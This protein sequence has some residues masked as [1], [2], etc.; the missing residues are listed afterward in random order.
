MCAQTAQLSPVDAAWLHMEDPTNLMMVTG[1]MLLKEPVDFARVRAIYRARLLQ[2]P[3]FSQRVVE[4]SVPLGIPHWEPDPHFVF[5]AHVHHVALP[6]PGTR[7][8]L[9][10]FL[11]DIASTPLDFSKPLWHLHVID[12]VEGRSAIAMR[13]HHCIGDG[14]ALVSVI[15]RLVDDRP[16]APV[17]L[18]P[19][20]R[21]SRA[22]SKPRGWLAGLTGPTAA[23]WKTARSVL[24]TVWQESTESLLHPS[25]LVDLGR[26]AVHAAALNASTVTHALLQPNDPITPLK[27]KLGVSKRVACSDPVELDRV[28]A[29]ARFADAK[30][31]D[32]LVAAM[33]GALRHYLIRRAHPVDGLTIHAVIPVDLRPPERAF[34]LGNVFGLVF[35]GMPVGIADPYERLMEVKRRMDALK[36][37]NEAI[38]YYS[39]LN[40]FGMTPKQVEESAVEFFGARATA[41]FTNVVGP[42]APMYLAGVTV[43]NMMF[44]VPQSGRLGMGISIY[45]YNGLVTLGVITDEGLAPDPECIAERFS[46]EFELLAAL[47]DA[48]S[49][50]GVAPAATGA[51]RE[52]CVAH[53]RTGSR[54]RNPARP[55]SRFCAVHGK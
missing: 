45:S 19:L 14:T 5:D 25:H 21:H 37:S 47:A 23:A 16:D 7:K 40:I 32:V 35:L 50:A 3:R 17:E 22:G 44:W 46:E 38:F 39:L 36:Q 55:G 2:F 53:T 30:V 54:C 52:Q 24:G 49:A 28:K 12:N 41:V 11:A 26:A 33:T 1:V 31:N 6:E 20:P 15:H 51:A 18:P 42:R 34:D 27:G 4:S 43:E 9:M 13:F 48:P 29:V 8:E 10:D